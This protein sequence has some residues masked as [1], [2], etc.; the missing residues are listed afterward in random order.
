MLQALHRGL[1]TRSGSTQ[2][3]L[4]NRRWPAIMGSGGE[5]SSASVSP[6]RAAAERFGSGAVSGTVTAALLQPLDVVRTLQQGIAAGSGGASS[7]RLCVLLRWQLPVAAV[8]SAIAP[9]RALAGVHGQPPAVSSLLTPAVR[10]PSGVAWVPPS[11]ACFG[12]LVCTLWRCPCS[13]RHSPP[14]HPVV[15]SPPRRG[16]Q[17]GNH[18]RHRWQRQQLRRL[19]WQ[20]SS[21]APPRAPLPPHCCPRW[22]W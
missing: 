22:R 12:A 14:S 8:T 4:P 17:R 1:P 19:R 18:H 2:R 5:T 15:P 3:G 6:L 16:A 10:W 11:A 9:A 7:E 21:P 20:P 13:W